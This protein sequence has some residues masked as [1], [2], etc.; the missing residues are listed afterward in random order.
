MPN[1]QLNGSEKKIQKQAQTL[2]CVSA[3]RLQ[4][5]APPLSAVAAQAWVL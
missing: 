1:D 3:P 4:R 5:T 2:I